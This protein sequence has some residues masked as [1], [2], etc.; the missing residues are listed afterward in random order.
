MSRR[1]HLILV[2]PSAFLLPTNPLAS[3]ERIALVPSVLACLCAQIKLATQ[4]ATKESTNPFM[5][6]FNQVR[7]SIKYCQTHRIPMQPHALAVG[8]AA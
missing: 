6:W 5:Q 4:D 7:R 8:L 1:G 3:S 2:S